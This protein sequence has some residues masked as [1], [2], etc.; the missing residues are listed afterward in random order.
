MKIEIFENEVLY[1]TPHSLDS[2][3]KKFI[4]KVST[5]I[6]ESVD[7]I[8]GIIA[9][10]LKAKQSLGK[11]YPSGRG[12]GS[13]HTASLPGFPPNED[14]GTL[15]KSF[16]K[17][18]SVKTGFLEF[19]IGYKKPASEYA[20]RLEYGSQ[21]IDDVEMNVKRRGK[22]RPRPF[23]YTSIKEVIEG[24]IHQKNINDI[25]FIIKNE[26][27]TNLLKKRLG[28]GKKLAG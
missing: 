4:K 8:D 15:R 21:E 23:F 13:L 16:V 20:P 9:K 25:F 12:D 11:Q 5:K 1:V 19:F 7:L 14:T 28:K 26:F 6:E 17:N 27:E 22:V 3:S 10:K 18:K 24:P 2:F